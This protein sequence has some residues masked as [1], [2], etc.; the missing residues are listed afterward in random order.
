MKIV[1]IDPKRIQTPPVRITSVFEAEIKE[2][3]KDDLKKDG[4]NQALVVAK[5]GED[6]WVIDGKNRLDEALLNGFSTVPCIVRELTLKEIQMRNLVLNRLRGRT[7]ASEE[8]MVIKDLF[9]VH[10]ATIDEVVE[11]TGMKRDRVEQ[12]L[13]ISGVDLEVWQALDDERIKVCH[14]FQ[15]SRLVDRS[16]QLRMLRILLQYSM[17]CDALREA[18]T[19]ALSIIA[20]REEVGKEEGV[21]GPPPV[22]TGECAV[23]HERYRIR[24]LTSPILCRHCF[25]ILITAY[26]GASR[27]MVL[28][29]ERKKKMA[30]EVVDGGREIV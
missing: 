22:P 15:L 14:A 19:E 23:C 9:E 8:V 25:A 5:S 6:L 30:L 4:I 17:T 18:I 11:K 16:A 29:V 1:D 12:L 3:F 28:E 2:M 13:A 24:E 26:D 7:K 27:E 21:I 10:G 20:E